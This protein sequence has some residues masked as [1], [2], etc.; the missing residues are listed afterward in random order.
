MEENILIL[1][2]PGVPPEEPSWVPRYTLTPGVP[3]V[4]RVRDWA[5]S[6][7]NQPTQPTVLLTGERDKVKI[8]SRERKSSPRGHTGENKELRAHVPNLKSI[9]WVPT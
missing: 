1:F 2:Y 5:P 9:V 7:P 8:K 4:V 3:G 6:C